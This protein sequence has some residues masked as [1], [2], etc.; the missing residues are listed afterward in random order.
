MA[1]GQAQCTPPTESAL[2]T[3]TTEW[4]YREVCPLLPLHDKD[5]PDSW[6]EMGASVQGMWLGPESALGS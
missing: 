2:P 4:I 6:G 1:A 5:P 3:T